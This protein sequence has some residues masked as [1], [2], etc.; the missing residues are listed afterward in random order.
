MFVSSFVKVSHRLLELQT[1]TEG[2]TLG[3]LQF[4]KGYNS[5]NTVDGVRRLNLCASSDEALYLSQ[6]F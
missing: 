2:S 6:G 5:V 1:W 4:T 3:W